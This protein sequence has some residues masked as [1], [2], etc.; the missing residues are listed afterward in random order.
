[1]KTIP[2]DNVDIRI[3]IAAINADTDVLNLFFSSTRNI[4]ILDAE[5]TKGVRNPPSIVPFIFPQKE[6]QDI[7]V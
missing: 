3:V 1:M 5:E 4:K 7:S 6:D 2:P